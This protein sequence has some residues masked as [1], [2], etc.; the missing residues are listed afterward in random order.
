[1]LHGDAYKKARERRRAAGDDVARREYFRI[2]RLQD[3]NVEN[4]LSAR[5][6]LPVSTAVAE[7]H[8]DLVAGLAF[9][10]RED[11]LQGWTDAGRRYQRDLGLS[12]GATGASQNQADDG[13]PK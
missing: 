7:D 5:D 6:L 9:E 13:W 12:D 4:R 8:L 11:L 2:R 3:R 1:M 10:A